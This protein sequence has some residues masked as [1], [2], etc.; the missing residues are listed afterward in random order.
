[1]VFGVL[2]INTPLSSSLLTHP[3][4]GIVIIITITITKV[5]DSANTMLMAVT[6]GSFEKNI[7]MANLIYI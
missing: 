2:Q 4:A 6:I 1:M 7:M 5:L 3:C